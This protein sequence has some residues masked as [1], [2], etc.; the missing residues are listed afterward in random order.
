MT[1]PSV[2][3][4]GY[5]D[6]AVDLT[7]LGLLDSLG[8]SLTGFNVICGLNTRNITH[9][10]N[11]SD[12]TV[13]NCQDPEEVP[14]V[15]RNANSQDKT[16]SGTGLHNRG[17]TNVIRAILSK[18]L[19]YRF[20]EGEPGNDLVSQ[21]YWQGPFLLQQ[22]QEGAT[23]KQN[24][25]SQFT[26]QSDGEVDWISTTAAP[27]TT[28]TATPL[29]ATIATPWSAVVSG[30]RAGSEIT[31]VATGATAVSF[32]AATHTVHAT[33]A[34]SG[35]KSVKITE[36]NAEATNSPNLTTLTVVVS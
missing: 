34:T 36:T 3:K 9:Q 25:T 29:T 28:L 35:S 30:I 33:W 18:T 16:M 27:L 22:W 2:V 12:E 5:F 23:I 15:S 20:I 31:V 13:P 4:G 8:I 21:G 19:P 14:W 32:D 6:V 7:G 11:T 24:V 1:V 17:Q 26:W 10:V